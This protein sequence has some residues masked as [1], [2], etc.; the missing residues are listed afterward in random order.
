[1]KKSRPA[2]DKERLSTQFEHFRRVSAETIERY[3]FMSRS[4]IHPPVKLGGLLS[5]I[6]IKEKTI[7]C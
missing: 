6:L 4:G 2:E 3:I 5:K 1:M 7:T